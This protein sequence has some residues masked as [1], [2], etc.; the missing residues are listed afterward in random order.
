VQAYTVD[1]LNFLLFGE[2]QGFIYCLRDID[3]GQIKI[4]YSSQPFQRFKDYKT[5]SARV[6]RLIAVWPGTA[7][8]ETEIHR[9]FKERFKELKVR[10]EWFYPE[11]TFVSSLTSA[12]S[13]QNGPRTYGDARSFEA[14][15]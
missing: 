8:E 12:R 4:G 1:L 13:A 14:V 9:R 11:E 6:P 7:V 5:H 15:N 2:C 10:G 3:S